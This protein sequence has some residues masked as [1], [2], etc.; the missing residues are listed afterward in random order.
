M[1]QITP[2]HSALKHNNHFYLSLSQWTIA[3][4]GM[5]EMASPTLH[6]VGPQAAR[7]TL[8]ARFICRPAHSHIWRWILLLGLLVSTFMCSFSMWPWLPYNMATGFQEQVSREKGPGRSCAF[9][10]FPSEAMWHHIY[11]ILFIDAIATVHPGSRE[12]NIDPLLK[13]QC[14]FHIKEEHIE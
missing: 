1:Q 12:E 4:W 10:H 7:F 9:Y 6:H 3:L 8:R 5:A 13:G 2:K 14:G 11:Y